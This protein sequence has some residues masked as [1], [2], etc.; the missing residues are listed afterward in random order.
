MHEAERALATITI[1]AVH[2]EMLGSNSRF[3][4]AA[5]SNALGLLTGACSPTVLDLQLEIAAEFAATAYILRRS[6]ESPMPR[7][8]QTLTSLTS[9]ADLSKPTLHILGESCPLLCTLVI[10]A[11]DSEL[12][13]LQEMVH[14]LHKLLPQ[15][16]HLT[17]TNVS[18][19]LPDMSA[20]SSVTTLVMKRVCFNAES[21]WVC[22]PPKL[23]S[24]SC[25]KVAVWPPPFSASGGVCLGKLLSLRIESWADVASK[26]I[27]ISDFNHLLR[28]APLLQGLEVGSET[29]LH[30]C[31]GVETEFD[32]SNCVD[33]LFFQQSMGMKVMEKIVLCF[34]CFYESSDG[35][36]L[37]TLQPFIADLPSMVGVIRCHLNSCKPV[38]LAQLLGAFPSV[39]QL[40]L[41]STPALSC[42]EGQVLAACTQLTQLEI[43][44]GFPCSPTVL[45]NLRHCLPLCDISCPGGSTTLL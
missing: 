24:L 12:S 3:A 25:G 39:R 15:V 5:L 31:S 6:F 41:S 19:H 45:S 18:S 33:L 35:P 36:M 29:E 10:T 22:L 17:L 2:L 44:S 4:G 1:L 37:A 38:D 40:I 11:E 42:S 34:T 32:P 23:Q 28:A 27:L 9:E 8:G 26:G 16:T 20:T 30:V 14:W 13:N 7:V 21:D 43:D